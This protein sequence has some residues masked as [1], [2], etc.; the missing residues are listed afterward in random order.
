MNSRFI[1]WGYS[2][3]YPKDSDWVELLPYST[4]EEAETAVKERIQMVPY[5]DKIGNRQL[6]GFSPYLVLPEGGTPND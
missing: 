4:R 1:M 5:A 3:M 6:G 2:K